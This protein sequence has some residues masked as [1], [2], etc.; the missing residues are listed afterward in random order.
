MS[1]A[2][3]VLIS[4]ELV[5]L[6]KRI[7]FWEGIPVRYGGYWSPFAGAIEENETPK[8]AAQRELF[9][10]S[11]VKLPLESFKFQKVIHK[12]RPF[13]LFLAE[14]ES[15]PKITL[16]EEHTELGTFRIDLL[17]TID[18]IDKEVVKCIKNYKKNRN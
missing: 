7:F 10:E 8:E 12:D 15:I 5:I 2:G 13:H 4:G 18:P 17:H 1:A 11:G 16:D 14:V 3:V 6:A 9:E